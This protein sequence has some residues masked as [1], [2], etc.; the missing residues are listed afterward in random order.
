M[1]TQTRN[2]TSEVAVTSTWSGTSRHL[3]LDDHPDSAN[4]AA[5]VTTCSGAGA[6]VMGF[7]AFTIP[8][9]ST[10]LSVQVL[11]YDFK[12]GS[13][14]SAAGSLLRCN[15]T[16]NRNSAATHNP[17]NGNANIAL[18]TDDYTT[19]PKS[20]AAW[21]VDEVNGVGT[22]GLT[23][24]GV[25]VTDASPTVAFS[26][27]QLQV[28]YTPPS[29]P[30]SAD[31]TAPAFG[32]TPQTVTRLNDYIAALT[33][34]SCAV[35]AQNLTRLNDWLVELAAPAVNF[36]AQELTWDMITGFTAELTAATFSYTAQAFAR[37]NDYVAQVTAASLGVT[38]QA[39]N[40]LQNTIMSFTAATFTFVGRGLDWT[41]VG[42]YLES[43]YMKWTRSCKKAWKRMNGPSANW[44]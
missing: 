19:N 39:L 20:A 40:W 38:G 32:V 1:A 22:N 11:Y 41:V 42:Q 7:S 9:N 27:A 34:Q 14:A 33:T 25:R 16:T 10:S 15:D 24:F 26:S 37:F 30:Y 2:P 21:T 23:A 8:A 36:T 5:D 6:L 29:T 13:Q 35:T 3:L 31:L 44:N 12:N 28:T 43:V 17:G 18:R 4:P